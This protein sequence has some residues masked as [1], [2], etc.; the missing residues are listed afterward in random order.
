MKR[1]LCA[2]VTAGVFIFQLASAASVDINHAT[3]VQLSAL[4]GLGLKKAQR[5]VAYRKQHGA[6]KRVNDLVQVK[7]IGAKTLVRL[8]KKNP[9]QLMVNSVRKLG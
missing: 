8:Q 6:F 1:L 2:V 5:I 9:G 7:G 3:A 4:K